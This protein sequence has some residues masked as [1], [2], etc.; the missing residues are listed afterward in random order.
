MLLV[1]GKN[2]NDTFKNIFQMSL[3]FT[4]ILMLNIDCHGYFKS[5][6]NLKKYF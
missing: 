3:D 5:S 6:T 1:I 4:V 2:D